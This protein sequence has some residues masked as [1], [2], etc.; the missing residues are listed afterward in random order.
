M[1][2][3]GMTFG[4]HT[5]SHPM[6]ENLKEDQARAEIREAGSV[7][8]RLPGACQVL[9]YPFGSHNASTV[10][11]A[12]ELGYVCLLEVEGTNSPLDLASIGRINISSIST[13]ALFARMEIVE[14]VKSA[15][16]P[17]VPAGESV[18]SSPRA[19]SRSLPP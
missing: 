4:N 8:A 13:A 2:A 19:S 10:R 3:G 11:I 9:A 16:E 5:C 15:L 6:L 1:V 18:A 17:R 12:R 14:P 7:L